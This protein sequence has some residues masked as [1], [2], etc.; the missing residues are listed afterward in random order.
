MYRD[1]C[2][3]H[4][5]PRIALFWASDAR[6]EARLPAIKDCSTEK[7]MKREI[8]S[9]RPRRGRETE[10]GGEKEAKKWLKGASRE[11]KKDMDMPSLAFAFQRRVRTQITKRHGVTGREGELHN[12]RGVQGGTHQ[13]VETA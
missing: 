13:R 3:T 2:P 7:K 4:D 11:P 1:L 8:N 12:G 5:V 10:E 9:T 6:L